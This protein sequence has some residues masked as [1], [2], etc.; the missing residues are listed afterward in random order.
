MTAPRQPN[1]HL[2]SCF[3]V[4]LGQSTSSHFGHNRP[5]ALAPQMKKASFSMTLT[6]AM[7]IDNADH[8]RDGGNLSGFFAQTEFATNLPPLRVLQRDDI[9][10]EYF[11][12]RRGRDSNP[13]YR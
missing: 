5:A 3:G 10:F 12:W 2:D 4:V 13:C 7:Q 9:D 8:G 11:S 6:Y 1:P